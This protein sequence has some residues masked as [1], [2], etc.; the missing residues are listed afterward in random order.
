[1]GHLLGHHQ[2]GKA[3]IRV[4]RLFR[5]SDPHQI[6]DYNVSVAVSGDI[7]ETWLSGDNS[8]C[9]TTDAMKNTVNAFARSQPDAVRQPE[10]FARVLARHFVETVP[11]IGTARVSIESYGWDRLAGHPHAFARSGRLVRT[12]SVVRSSDEEWVTSGLRDLVVLKTTDSEF[13]GFYTDAYTTLPPTQD[14]ILATAV[15]A[16]WW[17]T[18]AEGPQ[19]WDASHLAVVDA[20][21]ETFAG[22]HSLALQQTLFAMGEAVLDAAKGVA[23]IRLS[24]PNKHHF[25]LDLSAFGLDNPGEVF[26]ADDRPYGLIEGTVRREGAGEPGPAYDPGQAW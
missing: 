13:W 7:G 10:E 18:P 9:L 15:T 4:V 25:L 2:Y 5:D 24:M 17:H 26:H 1:M 22:H 6:V 11:Q 8:A 16:Q 14:R 19:D 23:E 20:L 3:E 21:T 12:C